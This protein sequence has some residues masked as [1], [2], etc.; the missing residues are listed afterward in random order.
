MLGSAC[1]ADEA[2]RHALTRTADTG[3][4]DVLPELVREVFGAIR[5]V[6]E[7]AARHRRE[8]HAGS[9]LPEP[10]LTEGGAL[11]ALGALEAVESRESVS[12]AR[13]VA[14]ERLSSAER[15]AYVLRETFG[16]GSAETAVVLGLPEVQCRALRRRARQRV[17]ES[18]TG[19][20]L[21]WPQRRQL[22][23]DLMRAASHANQQALAELLADDVVAWS[24]GGG[25]P[26]TAR[27]PALGAAKVARFL[28]GLI[29]QAPAGT[30]GR[31]VEINGDAAV[32]A[33]TGDVV[34][35]VVAPEFGPQGLVGI[36]TVADP[37][38]LLFLNRQ[39]AR[40]GLR[41]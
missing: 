37:G 13:L 15:A 7:Q 28:A 3:A 27:R 17:R 2:V 24:D 18:A 31:I 23:E 10:V 39:W 25:V 16:Y 20:D 1:A 12:M 38:R 22:A 5:A 11:G 30:R 36:R 26:G 34:V 19:V 6:P 14:L 21:P 29:S 8:A 32:L 9:W 4:G 35:A 41:R 33:T 40:R